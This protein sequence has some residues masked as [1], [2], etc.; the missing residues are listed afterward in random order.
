MKLDDYQKEA[1]RIAALPGASLGMKK[2]A[3]ELTRCEKW[4]EQT[5]TGVSV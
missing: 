2:F 1:L 4:A 3:L 5:K